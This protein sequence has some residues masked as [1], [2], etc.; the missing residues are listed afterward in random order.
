V[1][2]SKRALEQNKLEFKLRREAQA[3]LLSLEEVR[4][5]LGGPIA[6]KAY[7]D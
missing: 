2:I 4:A 3:Q 6:E 1:T 5:R 7:H